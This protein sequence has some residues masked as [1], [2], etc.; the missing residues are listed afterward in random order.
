MSLADTVF[1]H[2]FEPM[3]YIYQLGEYN[4]GNY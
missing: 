1:I 2:I 4:Y 3:F